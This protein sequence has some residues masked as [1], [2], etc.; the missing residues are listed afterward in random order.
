MTVS[1]DVTLEATRFLAQ[2][3][4]ET[5]LG[6][7]DRESIA[8]AS[9]SIADTL[10]VGL[11]GSHEPLAQNVYRYIRGETA[12]GQ[13]M[14]LGHSETA[15]PANAAFYNGVAMHVLD[16]D[17]SLHPAHVHP[18][19]HI[20]PSLLAAAA[21]RPLSGPQ[22]LEAY[23]A[24]IEFEAR[25]GA[26]MPLSSRGP[27]WHGVGILGPLGAAAGCAK[28]LG[29]DVDATA[30]AIGI[31]ASNAAGLR[32]NRGTMTKPLHAGFG[33]QSGLAAARLALA[34]ITGSADVLEHSRGYFAAFG[35]RSKIDFEVIRKFGEP[36]QIGPEGGHSLKMYPS[37][38]ASHPAIEAALALR[39]KVDPGSI[40]RI[41]VG[42]SAMTPTRL[43]FSNPVNAF[44]AKLSLQFCIAVALLF[45]AVT[46]STFAPSVIND[47]RV[48]GIMSL[49]SAKVDERVEHSPDYGVI[50]KISMADGSVHER[51]VNQARGKP[52]RPLSHAELSA[53]FVSCTRTDLGDG[54]REL[55]EELSNMACTKDLWPVL[56]R[57]CGVGSSGRPR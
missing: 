27:A 5:K 15:S 51:R 57:F 8:L 40:V 37:C 4:S 23:I 17:D 25:V 18:T 38:A 21:G 36:W 22:L 56:R 35:T 53:K 52:L 42:T 10:G 32:A 28:L 12:L 2:A 49:M 33:A 16:F 30:L 13:A 14:L 45:G 44:Q 54:P 3:I 26:A 1:E 43:V 31:A 48:R 6:S 50:I 9:V 29:A 24:G 41:E 20:L 47:K 39:E 11:A 19:C 46:V 55:F 34:G 7:I